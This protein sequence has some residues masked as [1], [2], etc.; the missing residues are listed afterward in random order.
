[1]ESLD[2]DML[3]DNNASISG[4]ISAYLRETAKWGM[5][6]AIMGYVGIGLMVLMSIGVMI[7]GAVQSAALGGLG[8]SMGALGLVYLVIAVLYFFPVYYLH[9]FSAK[10][11]QGLASHDSVSITSGFENLK[12]LFKFMGILCIVVLSIYAVIIIGAIIASTM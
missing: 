11:K 2:A 5:F 10:M 8:I 1:M 4:E 7:G 3:R 6:L 12:S 9:Q